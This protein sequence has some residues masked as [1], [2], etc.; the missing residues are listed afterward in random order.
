MTDIDTYHR[1]AEKYDSLAKQFRELE[2]QA[3]DRLPKP[4]PKPI[5]KELCKKIVNIKRKLW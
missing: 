5:F 1:E 4:E 3:I 2:R